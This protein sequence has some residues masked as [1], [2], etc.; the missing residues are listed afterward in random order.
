MG[1]PLALRRTRLR[2]ACDCLAICIASP[3]CHLGFHCRLELSQKSPRGR[4]T[5]QADFG[6]RVARRFCVTPH[7]SGAALVAPKRR[8]RAEVQQ[9]VAE[10]VS[11]VGWWAFIRIAVIPSRANSLVSPLRSL[12]V[13]STPAPFGFPIGVF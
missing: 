4:Y 9:L 2:I 6:A 12:A 13:S 7:E 10:F 3:H 5:K 8:T 1:L 11:V